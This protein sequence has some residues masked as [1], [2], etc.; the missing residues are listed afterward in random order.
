M[1]KKEYHSD[2]EFLRDYDPSQFDRLALTA[3]VL[4]FSVSS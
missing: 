1:D 4:I 2:E 3:D